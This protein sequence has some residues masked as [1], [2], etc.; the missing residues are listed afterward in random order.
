M[1]RRQFLRHT[2]FLACT[3]P[4]LQRAYSAEPLLNDLRDRIH[5]LMV[6]S[7]IGD[8]LG[9]PIEFQTRDAIQSLENP[10]KV[11]GP[12]DIINQESLVALVSRLHLRTYQH[13]RPEPE[14]YAHWTQNAE[15]GSITDDSPS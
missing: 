10:P 1:N 13:L 14:P 4:L 5:G 3:L 12:D 11:W 15:P 9:G 8:A 2:S 6:G 7:L